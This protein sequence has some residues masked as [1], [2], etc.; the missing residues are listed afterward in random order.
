MKTITLEINERSKAG[1][2]VLTMLKFFTNESKSVK[3]IENQRYNTQTEAVIAKAKKGIDLINTENHSD[4]M[5][6]LRK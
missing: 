6:K 3:V 4:L 2:T 1:K 5:A